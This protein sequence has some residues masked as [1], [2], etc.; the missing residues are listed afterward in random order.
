MNGD[1][2]RIKSIDA[3]VSWAIL[4][5]ELLKVTRKKETDASG[6]G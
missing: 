5:H 4:Q 6:F 2:C 1:I 3:N